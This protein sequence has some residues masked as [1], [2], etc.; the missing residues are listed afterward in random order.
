MDTKAKG[1]VQRV[2]R[3]VSMGHQKRNECVMRLVG[4]PGAGTGQAAGSNDAS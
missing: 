2:A 4:A 3:H 1:V